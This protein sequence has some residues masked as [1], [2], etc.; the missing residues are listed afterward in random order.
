[1]TYRI[2]ASQFP[3]HVALPPGLPRNTLSQVDETE[4]A[5]GEQGRTRILVV[6][7][8]FLIALQTETALTEAGFEVIGAA[9]TAEEAIDLAR[10]ERPSL[11]VMD[12]RLASARDGI[13]AA[14]ELFKELNIRCIFATAHDDPEIRRR[15]E[16]YAPLGW[17]AKPYTMTSLVA[18]VIEAASSLD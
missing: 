18:L 7:D 4:V 15:A 5:P 16:P 3:D 6:E 2:K 17:L 1:V 12:I 10:K 13:D 9:T 11:A 8:D 14:R